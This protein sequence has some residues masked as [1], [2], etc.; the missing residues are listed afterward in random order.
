MSRRE[1]ADTAAAIHCLCD[2]RRFR[3]RVFEFFFCVEF[4]EFHFKTLFCDIRWTNMLKSNRT[5]S[6]GDAAGYDFSD[7]CELL[8]LNGTNVN[9]KIGSAKETPLLR[10]WTEIF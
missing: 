10:A 5:V 2:R 9:E 1:A 3:F 8:I 6:L 4:F 7:R